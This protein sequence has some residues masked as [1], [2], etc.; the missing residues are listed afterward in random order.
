[1]PRKA[2]I[3]VQFGDAIEPAQI[4][5]LSDDELVAEVE[6]SIRSCHARARHARRLAAGLEPV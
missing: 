6:R 5:R 4:A 3:H 2:V 1:L